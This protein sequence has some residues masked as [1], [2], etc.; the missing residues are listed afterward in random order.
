MFEHE[1]HDADLSYEDECVCGE[2]IHDKSAHHCHP[3]AVDQRLVRMQKW[4]NAAILAIA[5][6]GPTPPRLRL[7]RRADY[8]T[9]TPQEDHK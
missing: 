1:G 3:M 7:P 9:V 6:H 2:V 8:V 5:G 4:L